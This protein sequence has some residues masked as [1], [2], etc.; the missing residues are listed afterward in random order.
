MYYHDNSFENVDGEAGKNGNENV[1]MMILVMINAKDDAF[2]GKGWR[3][4][5]MVVGA[6][7]TDSSTLLLL[8]LVVV[9]R[10]HGC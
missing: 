4:L 3:S 10:C 1:C 5:W 8:L 2:G 6:T 7:R 9:L